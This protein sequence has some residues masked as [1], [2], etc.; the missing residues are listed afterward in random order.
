MDWANPAQSRSTVPIGS[1]G[2]AKVTRRPGETGLAGRIGRLCSGT[3]WRW[4]SGSAR[5][6]AIR[7][8]GSPTRPP[9]PAIPLGPAGDRPYAHL[10]YWAAFVLIGDPD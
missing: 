8:R 7:R 5:S 4:T 9:S 10:Y 6:E 3:C 1:P 2:I